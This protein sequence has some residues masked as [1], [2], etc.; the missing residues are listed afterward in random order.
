MGW[1][2]ICG[3]SYGD[4]HQVSVLDI[5]LNLVFKCTLVSHPSEP[6]EERHTKEPLGK[7]FWAR[8]GGSSHLHS[9][10]IAWSLLRLI[11]TPTCK[12]G[13]EGRLALWEGPEVGF[14]TG[15]PISICPFLFP[16]GMY[17][18]PTERIQ[19]SHRIGFKVWDLVN[20]SVRSRCAS[21]GQT[22]PQPHMAL[23]ISPLDCLPSAWSQNA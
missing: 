6:A 4:S 5:C 17:S 20:I 22:V 9:Y 1:V 14:G 11:A 8:L 21:S 2:C 18:P 3:L 19:P 7:C 12:G 13:W 16:P 15:H 23:I 10:P